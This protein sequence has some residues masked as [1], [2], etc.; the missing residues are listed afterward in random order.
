MQLHKARH[1]MHLERAKSGDVGLSTMLQSDFSSTSTIYNDTSPAGTLCYMD[2][3]YQRTGL[4]SPK[5]MYP[6]LVW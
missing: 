3:E 1:L 6:P 5:S 2:P 4:V